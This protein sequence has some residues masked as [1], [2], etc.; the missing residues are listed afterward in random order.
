MARSRSPVMWP[1]ML[2][3]SG[4]RIYVAELRIPLCTRWI[5]TRCAPPSVLRTST[6]GVSGGG[7]GRGRLRA[8][9]A[10]VGCVRPVRRRSWRRRPQWC[11]TGCRA[12]TRARWIDG[13]GWSLRVRSGAHIGEVGGENS[14]R[15]SRRSARAAAG[16]VSAASL[17]RCPICGEHSARAGEAGKL[18]AAGHLPGMN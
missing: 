17:S 8:V 15:R 13:P 18:S 5:G 7:A 3:A 12:S 2:A 6:T 16:R 11:V 4:N 14:S 10:E 9:Q 1:G